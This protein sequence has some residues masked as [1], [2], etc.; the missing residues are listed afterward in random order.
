MSLTEIAIKRPSLIVVIFSVL[1]F[2]GVFSYYSLGYELLPKM[3]F[4]MMNITTVYPG[5]SPA[6][7]ENSVTKKIEDAIA[8]LEGVKSIRAF[9][10]EGVSSIFVELERSANIEVSI[11]TAQRKVNAILSTLPN[12]VKTPSIMKINF[13]E[14]PIMRLA[15][16]GKNIS[17][18]ELYDIVKQRIQPSLNRLDGVGQ[19]TLVGGDEREIKVNLNAEKMDAYKISM[20]QVRQAIQNS[21]MDFPTGK[22]KTDESQKIIRLAGKFKNLQDLEN[23]VVAT[24]MEG[25][26]V[27]LRDIAEVQDTQKERLNITHIDK[28]DAIGLLVIKQSDANAVEVKEK[29]TKELANLTEIYKT[30]GVEFSVAQD[31][32]IF[33]MEA[34]DA[35]IHDLMLAVLLVAGVMLLFLHSLRNAL[36]VMVAIPASL[37]SVFIGMY[38]LG[39]TLN[40]M[41]LLG[42]SLVVGILVDDSI[43]VLENIYRHLEMGKDSRKAALDGRNEIGFTAMSITLVDVVVF[44]PITLV[45]GMISDILRQFS[46]VVVFSTLMSLF[47]SFTITPWLASRFSRLEKINPKTFFGYII[48]AFENW[49]TRLTERYGKVLQWSLKHKWVVFVTTIVLFFGSFSLVGY[50]FI[51]GEFVSMGDQ[52]E[53]IIN[54]ELPKDATLEQTNFIT[55]RIEN[56]LF[57]NEQ[58]THVFTTVGASSNIMEGQ[59]TAYKAEINVKLVD[60]N[61]RALSADLI[62]NEVKNNLMSQVPGVKITTSQLSIMGT[63][64]DAPIQI[65]FKGN[66]LD[67][68]FAYVSRLKEKARKVQGAT[69]V[70]LSLET[71]NPELNVQL[72][73][74]RMAELGLTMDIVG[75]TM[76]TAFNGNNDSKFKT[77]DYEYD[78]NIKLDAFDRRSTDDIANLSFVN[79]RGELIKL[80]QFANIN[81]SSG[82][83]RLERRSRTAAITL[84][85]QV[86]GRPVGTVGDEI[87]AI[88]NQQEKLPA[89]VEMELEGDL[90]MQG[91]AFGSLGIALLASILFVYLIMV[92]LYDSYIYPFVVLFSIPVAIIGALLALALTMQS[93]NIFSIL[94]MIMLVGLVA[95]NAILLVDFTTHLKKEGHTT[96]NALIEAGKERLRPILMTTVAMV[97]GMLP[98]AL[99]SGAGA[100]WKNGLAWVLIGGLSSSMFLTLVLVPAIYLTVDNLLNFI[101]HLRKTDSSA[102]TQNLNLSK[103]PQ[104]EVL[105]TIPD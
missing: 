41:T 102:N 34:S 3:N 57:K 4:P 21:N 77:G 63:A 36:I 17:P 9:S 90:K 16:K 100:E 22:L 62:A 32:T 47:V 29:I 91:D 85:C 84:E 105:T 80:K 81:Q 82:P 38:V 73:K 44:L 52:G 96:F 71:G 56:E 93:L 45:E 88:I 43:V 98:I 37:V 46:L 67:T 49:L 94:G 70:K 13:S 14:L 5:A 12:E 11:Q 50:G 10:Q 26:P 66:N 42:L 53:F 59:N 72:D 75:L 39:F 101:A 68:L 99:A 61:E 74:K 83:S 87:I 1:T 104:K 64:N 78:I 31:T 28:D 95:K 92:A 58:I 24:N 25:T 23:V 103:E 40:L 30:K 89:G 2:L 60:K 86:V 54:V 51:G 48:T 18:T 6:E 27:K 65:I 97:I 33:T 19:I 20:L 55:Q 69:D 8:S 76:Q 35:V 79:A 15:V 7:V